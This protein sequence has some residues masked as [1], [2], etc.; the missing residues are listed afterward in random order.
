MLKKTKAYFNVGNYY[1]ANKKAAYALKWFQKV[2]PEQLSKEN[3]KELDFKMGYA[4]L[5]TNHY[6]I[7]E[8]SFLTAYK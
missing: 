8:G 6:Q 3:K 2:A 5:K 1:F 7:S 4:L